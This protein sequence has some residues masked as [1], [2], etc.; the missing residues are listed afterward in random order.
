MKKKDLD[1]L[2]KIVSDAYDADGVV[3]QYYKHPNG[4]F[5]DTLAKFIAVE[6]VEVSQGSESLGEINHAMDVAG[7]QMIHVCT[8]IDRLAKEGWKT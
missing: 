5:G 7:T 3:W 2:M 4:D 1:K 6:C 8:A